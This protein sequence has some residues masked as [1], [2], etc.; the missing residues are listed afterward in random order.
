MKLTW[1]DVKPYFEEQTIWV[2]KNEMHWYQYIWNL[3]D[4]ANLTIC[5][6]L[7]EKLAVY[8][9][10]YAVVKIYT[11]FC[12]VAF[13]ETADFSLYLDELNDDE[14]KQ[15]VYNE[16]IEDS[17]SIKTV[18]EILGIKLGREKTFYSL[19]ITTCSDDLECHIRACCHYL[20]A[21][22]TRA[23]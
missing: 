13:G 1:S 17:D 6:S 21:I 22:K 2:D 18:F 23:N 7:T 12:E 15:A 16:L 19:W 11:D 5:N 3:L 4:E 9:K 10:I 8:N 14:V 20:I